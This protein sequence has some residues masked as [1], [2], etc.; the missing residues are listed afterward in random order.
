[1]GIFKLKNHH[2]LDGKTAV[3]TGGTSGIGLETAVQLAKRGCHLIIAYRNQRKMK[4]AESI[5]KTHAP[6]AKLD[7]LQLQLANIK[8]I[9][10]FIEKVYELTGLTGIQILINNAGLFCIGKGSLST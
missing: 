6:E 4:I 3:I 10:S 5:I 8:S 7:F 2:R 9:N 1:M